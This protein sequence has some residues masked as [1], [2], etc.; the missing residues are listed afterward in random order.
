MNYYH[1]SFTP[2]KERAYLC[3]NSLNRTPFPF[4]IRKSSFKHLRSKLVTM[5]G[6]KIMIKHTQ[7]PP[8]LLDCRRAKIQFA[9]QFYNIAEQ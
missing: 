6:A 1:L 8:N 7:F 4:S 2:V 9:F 5:V 3:N